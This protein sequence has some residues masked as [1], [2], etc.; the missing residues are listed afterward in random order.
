LNETDLTF[1]Q[2]LQQRLSECHNAIAIQ[3]EDGGRLSNLVGDGASK[4]K[5]LVDQG[6]QMINVLSEKV[7]AEAERVK[8]QRH[9]SLEVL[10]FFFF[11]FFF[12]FFI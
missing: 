9:K 1:L 8:L 6:S 5:E 12:F 2:N 11:F 3:N 7:K 10:N 4:V